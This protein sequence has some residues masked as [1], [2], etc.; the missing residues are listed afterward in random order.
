[1]FYYKDRAYESNDTRKFKLHDIIEAFIL[2]L[3][4]DSLRDIMIKAK[5]LK[6]KTLSIAYIVIKDKSESRHDLEHTKKTI[7]TT[8]TQVILDR[9]SR[10]KKGTDIDSFLT[11]YIRNRAS[12][13]SNTSKQ[14]NNNNQTHVPSV[15]RAETSETPVNVPRTA[16]V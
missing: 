10:S 8:K 4:N 12:K 1:V 16:P 6:N 2:G 15:P 13:T 11:A 5:A 7:K 14:G 9:I 3:K